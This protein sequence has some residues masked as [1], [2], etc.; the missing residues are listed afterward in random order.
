MIEYRFIE[1]RDIVFY[2]S[3]KLADHRAAEIFST[4]VAIDAAAALYISEFFW[5]MVDCSIECTKSKTYPWGDGAEFWNEKVLTSISGSLERLGF[6]DI[7]DSVVDQ[8]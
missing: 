5:R 3:G 2:Y 4:Q 1:E 7:W 8:Q 6:I